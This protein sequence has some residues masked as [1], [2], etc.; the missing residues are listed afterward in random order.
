MVLARHHI[1]DTEEEHQ[2]AK[3]AGLRRPT[4][5][6]CSRN[7]LGQCFVLLS[8]LT[9]WNGKGLAD[10]VERVSLHRC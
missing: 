9:S 1:G 3:T 2:L 10:P 8:A 5:S 4:F 6:L 7:F